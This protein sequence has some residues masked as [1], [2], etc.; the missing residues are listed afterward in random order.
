MTI[1]D[2]LSNFKPKIYTEILEIKSVLNKQGINMRK[3]QILGGI[4]LMI[5]LLSAGSFIKGF[6]QKTLDDNDLKLKVR[7]YCKDTIQSKEIENEITKVII[8][9]VNNASKDNNLQNDL[10]ILF[11][12]TLKSKETTLGLRLLIYNLFWGNKNE[13]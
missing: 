6:F 10:S 5:V 7:E 8:K 4:S 12:N 11:K 2:N 1:V 3:F 9:S 13:K